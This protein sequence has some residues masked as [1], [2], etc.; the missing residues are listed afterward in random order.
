MINIK[1]FYKIIDYENKSCIFNKSHNMKI[2]TNESIN[3]ILARRYTTFGIMKSVYCA[4]TIWLWNSLPSFFIHVRELLAIYNTIGLFKNLDHYSTSIYWIRL[5]LTKV[6]KRYVTLCIWDVYW[7]WDFLF[8]HKNTCKLVF[9]FFAL[10]HSF[11]DQFWPNPNLLY[12]RNMC[13][14]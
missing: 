13:H 5:M 10:I 9:I 6:F 2:I 7:D 12:T 14:L 1:S 8:V 4:T 11:S 3:W